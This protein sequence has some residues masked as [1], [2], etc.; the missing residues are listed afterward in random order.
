MPYIDKIQIGN[1]SY[2][3]K[4]STG[5]SGGNLDYLP[6][7]GGTMDAGANISFDNISGTLGPYGANIGLENS[8]N[9]N[10]IGDGGIT[11]NPSKNTITIIQDAVHGFITEDTSGDGEEASSLEFITT[12]IIDGLVN[13]S[14]DKINFGEIKTFYQLDPSNVDSWY[15]LDFAIHDPYFLDNPTKT[16]SI[17]KYG[18]SYHT[19][20]PIIYTDYPELWRSALGLGS[21]ATVSKSISDST[22]AGALLNSSSNLVT[23]RDVYYGLPSINGVHTYNSST[24]I[25]APT[26]AGTADQVLISNGSGAPSW[27]GERVVASTTTPGA[28]CLI[29]I[30]IS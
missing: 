4:D 11:L 8:N 27:R 23:E 3:I 16:T 28:D 24:T 17:L 25:Y 2:D 18:Q 9:L 13:P 10:L 1:T 6:L 5:G 21:L 12:N 19:T 20:Y 22:V 30:D 7:A 29:W 15:G 14:P 26:T